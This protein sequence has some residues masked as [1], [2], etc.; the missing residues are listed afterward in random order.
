MP[1]SPPGTPIA[2]QR[3][4][5]STPKLTALAGSSHS[6]SALPPRQPTAPNYIR[7]RAFKD[8][9]HLMGG[10]PH[11]S[12]SGS[13]PASSHSGSS[14]GRSLNRIQSTGHSRRQSAFANFSTLS[15]TSLP[16][17][18]KDIGFNAISGMDIFL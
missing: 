16:W 12:A 14:Q 5:S 9:S 7:E 8:E 10:S 15:E 4:S 11:R 1:T 6:T 18:T 3:A 2:D 13:R 17:T